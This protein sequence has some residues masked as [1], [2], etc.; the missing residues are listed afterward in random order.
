ML[1]SAVCFP[2]IQTYDWCPSTLYSVISALHWEHYRCNFEIR[3]LIFWL[4]D[5]FF[6]THTFPYFPLPS[7]LHS[8]SFLYAM[9]MFKSKNL[10]LTHLLSIEFSLNDFHCIQWIVTKSKSCMVTRNTPCLVL[11]IF[12][13]EIVKIKSPL[14]PLDRYPFNGMIGDRYLPRGSKESIVSIEITGNEALSR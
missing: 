6:V 12:R 11:V 8:N 3:K 4:F 13:D 7:L 10:F 2:E 9:V 14:L 1:I 5:G